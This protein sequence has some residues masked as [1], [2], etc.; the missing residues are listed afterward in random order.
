MFT[1]LKLNC[2]YDGA[3]CRQEQKKMDRNLVNAI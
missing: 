3:P 1:I 2:D